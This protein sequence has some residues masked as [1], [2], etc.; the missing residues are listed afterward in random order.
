MIPRFCDFLSWFCL[1]FESEKGRMACFRNIK[2][3]GVLNKF[4]FSHFFWDAKIGTPFL[5]HQRRCHTK[6]RRMAWIFAACIVTVVQGP[7]PT[8]K[9]RGYQLPA[10]FS[11]QINLPKFQPGKTCFIWTLLGFFL[12]FVAHL[13]RFA[14]G[15]LAT[16]QQANK[17]GMTGSLWR[18]VTVTPWKR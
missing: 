10:T 9:G 15:V 4:C 3:N 8:S 5:K 13:S 7:N 2:M 18:M 11:V 17:R 16:S 1:E 14:T 6:S 12:R